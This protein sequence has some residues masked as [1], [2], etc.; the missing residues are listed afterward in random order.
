MEY[1][2]KIS[3]LIL[4]MVSTTVM[5]VDLAISKKNHNRFEEHGSIGNNVGIIT[6]NTDTTTISIRDDVEQAIKEYQLT[7]DQKNAV[8]QYARSL[9]TILTGNHSKESTYNSAMQIAKAQK[10]MASK[11]ADSSSYI[12]RLHS[13]TFNNIERVQA[14]IAYEELIG[15][16][17]FPEIQGQACE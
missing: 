6:Y 16:S 8:R 2:L 7:D 12:K 14:Y 17:V 5:A 3:I 1:K 15:G 9:Q 11:I 4:F 13:L 10:C